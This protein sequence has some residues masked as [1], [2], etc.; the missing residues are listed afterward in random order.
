MTP[1]PKGD[2]G[3]ANKNQKNKLASMFE[4]DFGFVLDFGF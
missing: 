2:S 1:T 4:L 3:S